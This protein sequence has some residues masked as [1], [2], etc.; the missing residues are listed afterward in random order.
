MSHHA[1]QQKS[2]L[3]QQA[4]QIS[5]AESEKNGPGCAGF[6]R[7]KSGVVA[8]SGASSSHMAMLEGGATSMADPKRE[9]EMVMTMEGSNLS[10]N[11]VAASKTSTNFA[12][13]KSN[14]MI[15]KKEY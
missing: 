9:R 3:T 2:Y 11:K 5:I 12:H 15:D 14:K 1:K 4:N 7:G 10:G 13:L 6:M 8:L